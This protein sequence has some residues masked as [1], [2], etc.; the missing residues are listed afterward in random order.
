MAR[1]FGADKLGKL[2]KYITDNGGIGATWRK[3]IR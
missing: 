2:I 1:F 3:A